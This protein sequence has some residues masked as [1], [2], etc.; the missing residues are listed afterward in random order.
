[1]LNKQ[2][3]FLGGQGGLVGPVRI[4]FGC[5]SAAGSIIRNSEQRNDRL[6]M[7]G[8]MRSASVQWRPGIYTR[9]DRILTENIYYISGLYALKAWYHF[10][11][12]R[13][14]WDGMSQALV[15]G[16]QANIDICIQE[17]IKRLEAFGDKLKQ[18]KNI[19]LQRGKGQGSQSVDA[20]DTV[21]EKLS[22]LSSIFDRAENDIKT[23]GPDGETFIQ[24][25]DKQN[26]NHKKDYIGFIQNLDESISTM[27]SAWLKGIE[28]QIVGAFG[29]IE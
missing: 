11:R 29:L 21:L 15:S 6:I 13:F 28:D 4:A 23:P 12:S 18:S 22:R 7:G 14:T 26:T 17:R 16:L 25:I 24:Y 3:V 27:G 20:H 2:P 10:V 19:L 9:P 1:M 5:I 8:T